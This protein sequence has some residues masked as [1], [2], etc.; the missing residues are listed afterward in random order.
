LHARKKS[1]TG[2]NA[3]AVNFA[4]E[5]SPSERPS[6]ADCAAEVRG[7]SSASTPATSATPASSAWNV[8]L[9]K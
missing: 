2:T 8:S 9:V 1:A 5:A 7:A 6:Q 3:S 4:S